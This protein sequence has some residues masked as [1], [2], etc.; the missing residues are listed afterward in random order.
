[1][2]PVKLVISAFGPYAD[3]TEIDFE[4]FGGKGLYLITGDTGAGKTTIFDAITFAL[5]GE[6]SGDVRKAD[7]FRSKYARDEVP[8]YV[9][10]TFLYRGK[11][12]TVKRNPEYQR[13]KTRGT[14]YTVQKSDAVLTYPDRRLPVTKSQDVTKA[15]TELIGLDRRQFTQI[16]MIAQGDFQKLLLAGTE[17]R[18]DIFRQIFNTGLYQRVQEQLKAESKLQLREY[19]ELKRSINQYME[20]IVLEDM[21]DLRPAAALRELQKQKFDGRIGEALEL[22]EELCLELGTSLREMDGKLEKL[23]DKIQKE[24]QLIGN[25][26]RTKEQQKSLVQN[27]ELL[28][29]MQTKLEQAGHAY[30]EAGQNRKECGPL[31]E[32]IREEQKNLQLLDKLEEEKKALQEMEAGISEGEKQRNKLAGQKAALEEELEK[33]RGSR[34]ALAGV[35]EEKERLENRRRLV[36]SQKESL[37]QQDEALGQEIAR[38]KET[39]K[40]LSDNQEKAGMLSEAV[41]ELRKKAEALE[42]RDGLLSAAEEMHKRLGEQRGLLEKE[43]EEQEMARKEAEETASVL[44]KLS[45]QAER[46]LKEQEACKKEQENYKNIGEAVVSCRHR[47]E[48]AEDKLR[49]FREQADSLKVSEQAGEEQQKAYE[50]ILAR[51]NAQQEELNSYKEEWDRIQDADTRSLILQRQK[52]ELEE[53][54]AAGSKLL[55]ALNRLEEQRGKVK[56]AQQEYKKAAEEKERQGILSRRLE[57]QFLDAQAG[58]LARELK[59]GDAC[60]VCGSVHHPVLAKLPESAPE[61]EALDRQKELLSLA[62]A[63]AERCSVEAGN[64]REKLGEQLALLGEMAQALFPET[65]NWKFEEAKIPEAEERLRK[66]LEE[67][68][69]EAGNRGRNLEEALEAAAR[70]MERK[71]ELEPLIKAGEERQ[72]Q[73]DQ[74]RQEGQQAFGRAKGQLEERRKQ[75]ESFLSGLGFSGE[76][77]TEDMYARLQEEENGL[78]ARLEQAEADNKRLQD[79]ESSLARKEKERDLLEAEI[80]QNKERAANLKGRKEAA[81]GQLV[82]ELAKTAELLGEAHGLLGISDSAEAQGKETPGMDTSGLTSCLKN[83]DTCIQKLSEREDAI[84]E[85]IA[86]RAQYRQEGQQKEEHLSEAR[87]RQNELEKQLEGIKSRR[88]EKAGQLR[89]S[90]AG[91]YGLFAPSEEASELVPP[92]EEEL[93]EAVLQMKEKLEAELNAL[94]KEIERNKKDCLR[95]QELEAGIPEKEARIRKWEEEIRETELGQKERYVKKEAAGERIAQLAEQLGPRTR[96]QR[97]EEIEELEKRR[98]ELEAAFQTAEENF[99]NCNTQKEKLAAAIETI[100]KQLETAGEAGRLS[101]EEVQERRG[102]WQQEKKALREKRDGKNMALSRNQD[103]LGKVRT[104]QISIGA[105]EKKY[106]WMKALADTANGML[107]GKRKIEL[108]T[109]IQMTYFDR[110][111]R[112]AN[113]RLLTMSSGQYE[114]RRE[115]EGTNRKEKA[116]LELSVTD[117]YNGTERSVKTLSGGE[118]FQASLS[119]ALGLA[120]E[121]QSHAGGI[122][123]DSLFVDEGFG[124]L[125]EEALGQAMKALAQ[126]TEGNRLV[127]IISHVSELKE[128]I[129]RKI[130]VTKRRSGDGIGSGVELE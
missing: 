35:G 58:L 102:L 100:K 26:R 94:E 70:E 122:Q 59:E 90:L 32:R 97:M 126:L 50:R 118:S 4:R 74:E 99:R 109:Y 6:A 66:L 98:A 84:R 129:D 2:R 125:D 18:G 39:E 30:E 20:N 112:R 28:E 128:R 54:E 82:R 51:A 52:K 49:A 121:I 1:M 31:E 10:Y 27:R 24:D 78:R 88:Q 56:T 68:K 33:D 95:R 40:S 89:S 69:D 23:E 53:T 114:L 38:Q 115:E 110:I 119:L 113:L 124:S 29:G 103:I 83:V 44:E 55:E 117:H 127:G 81:H 130:I 77:S 93:R 36:R 123:M 62:E 60:P 61:K 9:E 14:G 64:L 11:Q 106:I 8:T 76:E 37:Y 63:R 67:A 107:G 120:D 34:A 48:A 12:Y 85:E 108:E 16:S 22:L 75:W 105:V 92:V 116:G 79:L 57:Q 5:Y 65:E 96:Q 25:I 13:P 41:G 80:A 15:V 71:K 101:E 46:L 21:E 19:E 17:E 47:A 7:M 42:D 111:I 45:A 72:Q 87:E 73:L 91:A 43:G 3:R 104:Q 86:V